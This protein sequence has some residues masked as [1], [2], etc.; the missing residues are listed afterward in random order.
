MRIIEPSVEI[1]EQGS[2]LEGI[3]KQIELAGRACYASQH[4]IEEGS[5]K[6]FVD[7]II[8]SGHGAML[9][10]GTVYLTFK[11]T[12]NYDV[13]KVMVLVNN[14]YSKC[15]HS[16][17]QESFT[18]YITTNMRVLIENGLWEW[19]L[20]Y[21]TEPTEFHERR[22]TARFQCQIA[23]SREFNRHRVDSIA[24][25]STRYCNYSKDKFDNE[26]TVST[27]SWVD[28]DDAEKRMTEKSLTY[29][30]MNML[31]G[32]FDKVAPDKKFDAIDYWLFANLSAEWAYMKLIEC[33]WKPQ[34]ARTILPLDT[35]TDLVH[36]AFV[37]DWEHFFEL[38]CDK[39]HAH[40]DAYYLASE[41]K[42]Q[43]IDR[44]Y[45]K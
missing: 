13:S 41:L 35:N 23:I 43:F 4:R 19:A 14:K 22:I 31:S 1:L 37:S 44:V 11:Y 25:Q 30:A 8:R 36:T 26:I 5:A 17:F 12:D 21:I 9:E 45:V 29:Y 39:N 27:P 24:E 3:Y 7:N 32:N 10:H 20:N 18:R 2:G 15:T 6:K 34:Q 38:R 28:K 40:P 42:K 33:G 16:G